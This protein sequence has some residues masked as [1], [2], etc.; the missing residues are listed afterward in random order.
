MK[1][2]PL[3]G[4]CVTASLLAVGLATCSL[5]Y[6]DILVPL[7]PAPPQVLETVSVW[8]EKE[9]PK[10]LVP[11]APASH[12]MTQV[13]SSQNPHQEESLPEILVDSL[14]EILV[15]SL[16]ETLPEPLPD[17]PS[18]PEPE[19]EPKTPWYGEAVDYVTEQSWLSQEELTQ[20]S[21]Q[22]T[23]TRGD[24]MSLLHGLAGHPPASE[25]GFADVA[26]E[27]TY[28]HATTWGKDLGMISGMGDNRFHPEED[29]SREELVVL[30]YAYQIRQTQE[31]FLSSGD[32][33]LPYTDEDQV[34][35]WAREATTW[36]TEEGIVSGRA[37]GS[38][39]PSA[40]ATQGEVAVV[41]Y[42]FATRLGG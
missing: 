8:E 15:D 31:V 38:F 34:S 4:R 1:I 36:A 28:A 24:V 7:D 40:S 10:I 37:D 41:F 5:A 29:V 16:P 22:D 17:T 20:F 6:Q 26:Q 14:P 13:T 42:N 9:S 35:F 21:P 39:D 11:V 3:M 2:F 30:L 12:N 32:H 18:E 27:A 19:P 33:T 23:T 25:E